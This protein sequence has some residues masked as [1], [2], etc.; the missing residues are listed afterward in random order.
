MTKSLKI[1]YPSITDILSSN[2][3]MMYRQQGIDTIQ[4][5]ANY[6]TIVKMDLMKKM[7]V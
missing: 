6:E 4:L 3:S 7:G 5:I 2:S 1:D